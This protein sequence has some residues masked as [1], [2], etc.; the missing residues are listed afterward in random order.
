[1]VTGGTIEILIM[2]MADDV[3]CK[4]AKE[5]GDLAGF[6]KIFEASVKNNLL[7]NI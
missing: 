7:I 3:L 5:L 4:L 6:A 2:S 1:M